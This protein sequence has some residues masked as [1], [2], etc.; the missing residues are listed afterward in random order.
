MMFNL[1][2][3][4]VELY[5][6]EKYRKG[7]K[8]KQKIPKIDIQTRE[9]RREMER[10]GEGRDGGRGEREKERKRGERGGESGRREGKRGERKC[11]VLGAFLV[12]DGMGKQ[13][14]RWW[15][16]GRMPNTKNAPKAACFQCSREGG[17]GGEVE[18]T[19]DT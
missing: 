9:E 7:N 15:W 1:V 19:Q 2:I 6:G 12:F 5:I 3:Y 17:A 8:L 13:E 10:W 14:G 4:T 11:A 18:I 16:S